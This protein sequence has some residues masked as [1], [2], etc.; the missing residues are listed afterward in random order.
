M[1][2]RRESVRRRSGVEPEAGVERESERV[3]A[4]AGPGSDRIRIPITGMTCAACATRVQRRLERAEGVR[5]AAVNFG[6]EQAAVR[7]DEEVTDLPSLVEVVRAAG[8]GARTAEAVLAVEGLEWASSTERLERELSSVTGVLGVGA[9]LA[10]GRARVEYVPGLADADALERAVERAGLRL[11]EPVEAEDAVEAERRIREREHRGL[12]RRFLFSAAVAL[13]SMAFM[14]PLMAAETSPTSGADLFHR[15][16][17]PVSEAFRGAVPWLYAVDPAA[18]KWI[19]LALTTPVLFWAGRPFLRGAWSG[20]LH[21]TADMNTLIAVGTGAAYLYSAAATVAPGLFTSGGLPAAVY[22]EA[23][24][25]IIALI[26]LGKLLE[27]GAKGRTS[28]AIRALAGLQ[29]RTARV[30]DEHGADRDVP[31]EEVAA[32]DVVRVRPGERIPVDGEVVEGRSAVD[33]SMLT[34]ESIPI[35]KSPGD[36]VF[37]GTVNAGGGAFRFRVTRVGRDT[38]LAQVVR[39]VEEAQATKAPIQRLADR[40]AG[41]FVPI[42]L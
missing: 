29:P 13:V 26:L 39:L 5:E 25:M 12:R 8:Y 32:G 11:A 17:A 42:V 34:G 28:E 2:E 27:A 31:I 4:A 36:E 19:L 14:L 7:Y 9:N 35:E 3:D 33:E 22:Y 6:T 38:A 37:G 21:R 23:V 40:I 20:L 16:L 24:A 1:S 18:L 30:V 10:T 41:V 15:L